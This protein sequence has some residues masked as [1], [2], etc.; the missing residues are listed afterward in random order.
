LSSY[1]CTADTPYRW[2][3]V[4]TGKQT[5]G[6]FD[7][8]IMGWHHWYWNLKLL[9]LPFSSTQGFSGA[10]VLS[11]LHLASAL[12]VELRKGFLLLLL[13]SAPIWA[14]LIRQI[15]VRGGPKL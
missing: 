8:L 3:K 1:P 5:F 10:G 6:G 11:V 14:A 15:F 2:F 13:V 7:S 12:N 4:P 9:L